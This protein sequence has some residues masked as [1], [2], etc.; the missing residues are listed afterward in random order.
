MTNPTHHNSTANWNAA[1]AA[2][3]FPRGPMSVIFGICLPQGSAVE[4]ESVSRL[5]EVTTRYGLHGT[6]LHVQGRLGMGFQAFHTHD[7]SRLEQQPVVDSDGNILVFDGRL[8][9]HREIAVMEGIGEET[10]ADSA[11]V[12]RGFT[13]WGED[14]FSHLVG[15]WALALWSAGDRVLYLARDHAGSRTLFYRNAASGIWWST[16]L[17]T[18]L[19]DDGFPDLDHEYI[20]RMISLQEIR[21]LTP[22]AGIRAVPAAHYIAIREGEMKLRPHWHWVADTRVVYRSAVEYEEHFRDLFRQAVKRRIGPGAPVLA[23]L[24]GGMDSSSIVCMADTIAREDLESSSLVDTVSYYDDTEPDWDERPYF[25]VVESRRNKVGI[26]IDCSSRL[27]SYEPLVLPGRIYPYPGGDRIS[28]DIAN[29]F[30]RSVGMGK[31][32]AILSGVGG[33]ELL[34]GV[35]TPMPELADYLYTGKILTVLWRASQWCMVA[36]RPIIHMLRDTA[37]F[38][39]GLYKTPRVNRDSV[40]PWLSPELRS[41]CTGPRACP[42]SK[43]APFADRPSAIANGQ[44]WWAVLETLPHL[45]PNLLGCYEYRYPYLDRDLVDFLHRIPR[46]QMV[47]PGRRR[48]LMRR[49]LREIVPVEILERKR[50]AYISHGPLTGLRTAREKIEELFS[51]PLSA[52]YGLI[53]RDEFLRAFRSELA[54]ELRWIGALA[55]TIGIEL[56]LRSLRASNVRFCIGPGR[57]N[58]DNILPVVSRANKIRAVSLRTPN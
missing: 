28:L 22:Y 57:A 35:P 39:A 34:G 55:K 1:D 24:S 18:F 8:D 32:R 11:L 15:D 10:V 19:S 40:P 44:A 13:R 5:A 50:K 9:N 7:R 43:R 6:E 21:D 51:N 33:D 48:F 14:C 37:A 58:L 16:H 52:E 3:Y 45:V 20:A 49:A 46:E 41:L 29:Q 53:D 2:Q 36:R 54:G 31:Y 27:P 56:W 4:R 17:E 38:T 23:E 12:L 26:H 47:Q 25:S 30:E 42:G